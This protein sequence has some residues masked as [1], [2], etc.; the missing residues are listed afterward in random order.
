M[1]SR[2]CIRSRLH[3]Q[4]RTRCRFLCV[5]TLIIMTDRLVHEVG[6]VHGHASCTEAAVDVCTRVR[7][8]VHTDTCARARVSLT[9][10]S[11]FTLCSVSLLP[12]SLFPS[13]AT[14]SSLSLSLFIVPHP[15]T[16]LRIALPTLSRSIR[17][18]AHGPP[19]RLT[20]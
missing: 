14:S 10:T 17:R 18:F 12:L 19:S 4:E 8:R 15:Y 16:Q 20:F 1:R 2:V 5:C 6:Q 3:E 7:S 9:P 13:H 11:S